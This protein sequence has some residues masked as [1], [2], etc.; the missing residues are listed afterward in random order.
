MEIVKNIAA[1]V[2]C[3]SACIGLLTMIVKPIRQRI[4]DAF[5]QKSQHEN[6]DDKF[7]VIDEKIDKLLDNNEGLKKRLQRVEEN[8]LENEADRI[9]TEL[10]DCGSRCRR[11]IRLHPEE[12]EHIRTIYHKYS[13]VLKQN[14]SGESEMNF[15]A[16]YYNN[17]EFPEY[18][19]HND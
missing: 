6:L 5:V 12:F 18:H 2:G 4:I 7:K 1:V 19:K 16:N 3:I 15:I 17:Q 10:Y 13:Q 14:G 8:V 9:R 11:G